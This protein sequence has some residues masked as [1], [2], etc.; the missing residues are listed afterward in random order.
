MIIIRLLP[1]F[2]KIIS[3]LLLILFAKNKLWRNKMLPYVQ[4]V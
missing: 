1:N 4:K 3:A 2:R